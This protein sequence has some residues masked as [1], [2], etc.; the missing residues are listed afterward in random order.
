MS[1]RET[2][3]AQALE[4]QELIITVVSLGVPFGWFLTL[5]ESAGNNST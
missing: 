5:N 1:A 2:E 4:S 3:F